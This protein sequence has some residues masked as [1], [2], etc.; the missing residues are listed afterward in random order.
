MAL[1]F[2]SCGVAV[3]CGAE[4]IGQRPYELVWAN[5]TNDTQ[6]PLV[7]FE[8]AGQRAGGTTLVS[9]RQHR[10]VSEQRLDSLGRQFDCDQRRGL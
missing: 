4:P 9:H 7:D 2:L 10:L 3:V 8:D 1:A 5:R 6:L